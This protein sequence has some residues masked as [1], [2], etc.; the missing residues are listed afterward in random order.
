M[1][2]LVV[3][4]NKTFEVGERLNLTCSV[5]EAYPGASLRWTRAQ[6]E[7]IPADAH[8]VVS[9]TSTCTGRWSV[10]ILWHINV[11]VDCYM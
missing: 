1:P 4:P 10:T 11:C 2:E 7:E 6:Y 9:A 5:N 8:K 3:N